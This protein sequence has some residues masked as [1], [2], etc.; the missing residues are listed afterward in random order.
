MVGEDD[1]V[2]SQQIDAEYLQR[3]HQSKRFQF[4]YGVITFRS[5]QRMRGQGYTIDLSIG[6]LLS[7]HGSE[8]LSAGI[9]LHNERVFRTKLWVHQYGTTHQCLLQPF[10]CLL[11]QVGTEQLSSIVNGE[12]LRSWRTL[13]QSDITMSAPKID[14]LG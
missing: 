10:K 1:T 14:V 13:I 3:P 12:R 8:S 4:R 9:G 7:Q 6:L 2:V 11:T 5:C